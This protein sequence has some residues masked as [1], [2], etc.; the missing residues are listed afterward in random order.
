MPKKDSNDLLEPVSAVASYLDNLLHEEPPDPPPVALKEKVVPLPGVKS[1]D[2][3]LSEVPPPAEEG[4]NPA[5]A[6]E[7]PEQAPPQELPCVSE[8]APE[9]AEEQPEMPAAPPEDP[10]Q[11]Y[12]FPVQCLMFQVAGHDLCIPLIDMGSVAPLNEKVMTRLPDTPPWLLGVLP[13]RGQNLRIV[14]S[15]VLLGIEG[16]H[17]EMETLHV[18]VFADEDFAIT[19]ECLG[20]VVYLQDEEIKWLPPDSGGL[21]MGTVR[22]SL[23]TLLS[24]DKIRQRMAALSSPT[25]S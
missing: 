11:R 6:R 13:H 12:R 15:A 10:R 24:P 7:Q 9:E 19:C 8:E 1:L 23:S 14:D 16:R 22:E 17:M 3:L 2:D 5:A 18:L 20:Q 25:G 21:S 4:A